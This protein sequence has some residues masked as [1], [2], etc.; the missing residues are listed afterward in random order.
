MVDANCGCTHLMPLP[1]ALAVQP[2]V[3]AASAYMRSR[4]SRLFRDGATAA[5]IAI[6]LLVAGCGLAAD[7]AEPDAIPTCEELG[8]ETRSAARRP[9]AVTDSPSANTASPKPGPDRAT[10]GPESPAT[11]VASPRST[12]VAF[13]A[14]GA[15]LGP[16]VWA[17]EIDPETRAPRIQASSFLNSV[18]VI[19]ATVAV[20]R[21]HAGTEFGAE[22]TYNR[23]PLEAFDNVIVADANVETVW[24]EFHLALTQP[25]VW[26]SGTY[27]VAI[28]V[29]GQPAV[30][31]Q[32]EVIEPEV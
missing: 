22:W 14:T 8:C 29:N 30:S 13:S 25:G 6:L 10:A 3:R 11:T 31:G 23:T 16:V 9:V 20:E 18:H 12:P 27:E 7:F 19:Y 15:T 32:I 24:I 17:S 5:T 28:S 26:P 2:Q 21:V 4:G 1:T